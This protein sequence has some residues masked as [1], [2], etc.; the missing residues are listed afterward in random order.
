MNLTNKEL[1]IL[2]VIVLMLYF[3]LNFLYSVYEESA[4]AKRRT[5]E[6][7]NRMPKANYSHKKQNKHGTTKKSTPAGSNQG[8]R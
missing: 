3:F 7:M 4:F 8:S 2:G 1:A 6:K 5:I